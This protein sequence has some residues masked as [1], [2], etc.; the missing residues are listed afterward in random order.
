MSEDNLDIKNQHVE[1]ETKTEGKLIS[2]I[3]LEVP[4]KEFLS[5]NLLF[6]IIW[7]GF[8]L[9]SFLWAPESQPGDPGFAD[10][11]K[12]EGTNP[13][14]WSVF[15]IVG[16]W[17]LLYSVVFL[18]ENKERFIPSWPFVLGAF[19][20]GM[21]ILMPYFAF[22]GVR[23]KNPKEKKGW[24][25]K[26]IDSRILGIILAILTLGITLYGIIAA[27]INNGWTEYG[28]MFLNIR[29]IHVMTIDLTLLTLF[30][31]IAIWA[32]MKRRNWQ[33]MK[34]FI[35]FSIP[36]LGGLIYL[37]LRPRLKWPVS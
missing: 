23:K 34:L 22:R 19:G 9:Y 14:A 29:F 5:F 37:V 4:W 28:T 36:L 3:K 11:M 12:I 16:V 2:R 33:N 35:I 17:A 30:Y 1:N 26:I 10:L 7:V 18:I 15:N 13:I 31:P 20:L 25:I 8:L 32:D 27:S 6:L 24:F 21:Y